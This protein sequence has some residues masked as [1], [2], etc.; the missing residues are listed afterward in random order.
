[1]EKEKKD[2][3]AFGYG[4]ALLIP[5]IITLHSMDHGL[6]VWIVIGLFVLA[7]F[8]I[9]KMILLKP[10]L[11]IWVL[12]V[13]LTIFVLGVKQGF[14]S[15][16]ILFLGLSIL[17]LLVTITKPKLLKP[18]YVQWMKAAHF[19][20]TTIT[21][22]ILALMFYCVFGIVGIV[23]RVLRKDL[24]NEKLEPLEKSYWIK[25]TKDLSNEKY[26]ENQF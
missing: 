13:Q 24:L 16:A 7:L 12:I 8:V 4:L 3:Y 26:Y 17:I 15:L 6:N 18:I 11:N 1:M 23:L 14:S 25:R 22:L 20:G 21:G 19:I 9:T 10:I 5:L 2:L